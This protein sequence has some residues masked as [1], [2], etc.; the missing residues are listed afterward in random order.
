MHKKKKKIHVNKY[1]ELIS[2]ISE[3]ELDK[4]AA[5]VEVDYK[6]KKLKG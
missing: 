4:L 6:V 2:F 5:E 1:K 3:A